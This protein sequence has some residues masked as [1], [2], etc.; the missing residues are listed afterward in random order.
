M[1]NI[2]VYLFNKVELL[3]FAGPYEVFT[4]SSEL[5]GYKLLKT[6]TVSSDGK[7]ITTVNG[8][9]VQP[10]YSF[11]NHP[12]VDIL[13]IP[14]GNGTKKEIKK[15]EVLDWVSKTIESAEIAFSVCSG[16]RILGKLGLLA[17]QEAVTHHE[18]FEDLKRISPDTRINPEKRFI[19]DGR[20][21][22]SGGISAGIDVSLYIVE[23]KFGKTVR[24]KT[25]VYMEY[26][27]WK[28][29]V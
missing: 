18:V 4:V 5:S 29:L 10:D 17:N 1:I 2:G 19:D 8:L 12:P 9:K 15:Q 22:T 20:I 23:R 24:D 27:D 16:A 14:G 25:T 11:Q 13:V 21:I 3:D 26:G 7:M 6:F 28:D